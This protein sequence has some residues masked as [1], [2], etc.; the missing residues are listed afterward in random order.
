M[1]YQST[2]SSPDALHGRRQSPRRVDD[3]EVS[4]SQESRQIL[5]ASVPKLP[6]LGD[7]KLHTVS[8]E[9]PLLGGLG[10]GELW[11]QYEGRARRRQQ[12]H[13]PEPSLTRKSALL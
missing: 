3:D 10:G 1:D 2:V 5:K 4:C 6:G 8:L 13:Q 11:G 12:G 7:Q 9:S